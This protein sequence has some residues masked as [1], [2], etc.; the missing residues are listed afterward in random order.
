[1][2]TAQQQEPDIRFDNLALFIERIGG[3]H[4]RLDGGGQSHIQQDGHVFAGALARCGDLGQRLHC[5]AAWLSGC[6]RFGFFHVG[7]VAAG[8]AVNDG[9]FAGGGDHLKLFGQI[10]PNGAAVSGHGAV[11]QAKAVK[12]LA[13]GPSHH[14]VAGLGAR[15]VTV[16][17]VGV[18]HGELATTHQAKTR[19]AL[20]AELGLDLVEVFGQLF[21]AAHFLAHHVG[22]H[23]FAGRLDHEVAAVAVLD[24]QKLRAHLVKATGLLP[25]LGRLHH[26]H[27][28]LDGAGAVHFF[29]HDGLDLAD[30][31]QAHGHVVVNTRAELLD[32]AGT[33][34]QFVTGNFSVSG[35]FLER[36]NQ[37][38]RSFHRGISRRFEGA[39]A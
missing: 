4:Q 17:A 1:M 39:S 30:H 5:R 26:G 15:H 29:A 6:Q 25:Q 28:H 16:K 32:H 21:V 33:G 31:A 34:H 35:G 13:V 3:Q 8:G 12:N 7:G 36:R 11:G 19:A 9:V 10:A 38:L 24:A 37:K 2:I 14:L 18:F 20:V 23:L 27:G 22:H